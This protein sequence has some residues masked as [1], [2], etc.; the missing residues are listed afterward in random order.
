MK[1]EPASTRIIAGG[2]V[3]VLL[4]L[5]HFKNIVSKVYGSRTSVNVILA[6]HDTICI[7][8]NIYKIK[9]F[10]NNKNLY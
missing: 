6:T 3:R 8:N 5:I 7:L 10:D 9:K 1:S 2:P 4:E